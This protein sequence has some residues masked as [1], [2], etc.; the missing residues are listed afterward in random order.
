MKKL[1]FIFPGQGSQTVGMGKALYDQ[2]DA[3]KALFKE[4]DNALDFSIT[5][6]CFKGPEEELRKTFNT[7][8]A[9]LTVSIACLLL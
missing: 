4:A 2:F 6:M 9:I 5:D 1:A 7:Q 8:P 3:V